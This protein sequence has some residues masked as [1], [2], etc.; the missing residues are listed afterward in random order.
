[1]EASLK[2]I[3]EINLE[4]NEDFRGEIYTTYKDQSHGLT[5]NHDKI[6][7]RVKNTLV[8]IHGDFNTHKLVACL[9]GKVYSVL[10]DYRPESKDY[11]KHKIFILSGENKKQLFIPPGIGNSFLVLSDICV[12]NYKLSYD[13]EYTDFDKQFTLKWDNPIYNI[14]WPIN[15]PILSE[16]DK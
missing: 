15:T 2:D 14:Y 4:S 6:C 8:G 16:R 10:V 1:M 7:T 12:Y 9:Y 11:L 3:K 13:G 5:F